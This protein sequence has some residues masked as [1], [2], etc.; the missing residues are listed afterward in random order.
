MVH[1]R[2]RERASSEGEALMVYILGI[3]TGLLVGA[4]IMFVATQ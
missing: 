1:G 2:S 3:L 4:A